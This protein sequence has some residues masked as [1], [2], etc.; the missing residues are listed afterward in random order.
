[1]NDIIE[2]K[3]PSKLDYISL[4]RLTA[5]SIANSIKLNVDEIED[6]KVC[7]SEA[8]INVLNFSHTKE[9]NIQFQLEDEKIS[10]SINDV[11][12]DIPKDKENEKQ[13]NMGLLIIN[14]L[15]DKVE[16]K[17]DKITMIKYI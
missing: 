7:I 2:L 14:S 5:S 15:M 6:I 9:I 12:E 16:F 8:C 11:L 3:I 1:M 10:I 4:I 17:N 13:G